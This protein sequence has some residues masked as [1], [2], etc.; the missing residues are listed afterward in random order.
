MLL[1]KIMKNYIKLEK[2]Y[3]L[4][5]NENDKLINLLNRIFYFSI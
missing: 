2:I 4:S 5:M 3:E 1:D